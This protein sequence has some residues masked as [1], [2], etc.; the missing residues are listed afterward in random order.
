MSCCLFLEYKNRDKE[1]RLVLCPL[2]LVL[3]LSISLNNEQGRVV[4]CGVLRDMCSKKDL[5]EDHIDTTV[6]P[7]IQK[8]VL[9]F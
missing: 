8:I 4:V 2:C 3:Y 7:G 6:F 9:R 5:R 1:L